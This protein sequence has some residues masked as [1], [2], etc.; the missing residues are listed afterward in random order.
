MVKK[1][2]QKGKIVARMAAIAALFQAGCANVQSADK[3]PAQIIARQ[4]ATQSMTPEE[5]E[6]FRQFFEEYAKKSPTAQKVLT[7]LY[8]QNAVVALFDKEQD[9]NNILDAGLS[10]EDEVGLNR[11][12]KEKNIPLEH[13][14]FHEAEHVLHLKQAHTNGI[15]AASFKSLDDVYIYCTIME[16]LAERKA[17]IVGMEYDYGPWFSEAAKER[18]EMAFTER[19]KTNG[20]EFEER[21]SYEKAAVILANSETNTLPNQRY[22][23]RDPNWDEIISIM[24]RGEV[25]HLDVL[26]EPTLS[27]LHLF[28]LKELEKNPDAAQLD[29]LDLSCALAHR[30]VLRQDESAL[31]DMVAAL[32]AETYTAC[33]K[34]GIPFNQETQY[35]FLYLMG[36]PTNEQRKMID[37]GE[38]TFDE[39]RADNLKLIPLEELFDG[40]VNLIQSEDVQAYQIYETKYY[41]KMLNFEKQVLCPTPRAPVRDRAQTR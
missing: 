35:S 38:K 12:L 22:F 33:E 40:A 34:T 41:G 14:F 2:S 30:S 25:T 37:S 29:D 15:N 39:V 6:H 10:N 5:E 9:E 16:G 28:I 19:M 4:L 3:E 1:V 17:M 36:W 26:P 7:D 32:L 13:T 24:S 21:L 20:R 8:N 27:F 18:G 31:K 23:K 11:A